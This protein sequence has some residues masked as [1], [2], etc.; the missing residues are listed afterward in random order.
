MAEKLLSGDT[1]IPVPVE[2]E[3]RMYI[4]K[5]WAA[6]GDTPL[7]SL[8][9]HAPSEIGD[10]TLMLAAESPQAMVQLLRVALKLLGV[11]DTS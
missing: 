7:A 3:G 1:D 11:K 9:V 8:L 5:Q 2:H 10:D 6:R 4:T